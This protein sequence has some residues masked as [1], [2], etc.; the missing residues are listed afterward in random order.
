MQTPAIA[1]SKAGAVM[2]I[3]RPKSRIE[4][5]ELNYDRIEAG[6]SWVQVRYEE[7]QRRRQDS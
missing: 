1:I 6:A 4:D 7:K 2:G 3:T 5:G